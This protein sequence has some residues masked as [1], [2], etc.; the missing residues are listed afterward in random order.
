MLFTS[1]SFILFIILLFLLY[2]II[3]KKLQWKLL[4][5]A[6]YLFYAFAGPKYLIYI[7][8]TTVSTYIA[9]HKLGKLHKEQDAYLKEHK[10]ELDREGKKAYKAVM[11]SKQWKWLLGTLLLNFGILFVI[12]YLNFTIININWALGIFG[13]QGGLSFVT[14][15]LP[16]GISFYTFQ[17]MG[18]IIDVYRGKFPPENNLGKLALFVSFFPQLI[19]GPISRYDDLAKT[20]YKE[21]PLEFKN[22]SFGIQRI[23]WGFFKKLVIADRM[24]I[25]VKTLMGDTS[26]YHGAFVVV[27]M[28]FYTFQLY[29]D[30]T[31]GIDITIGIAEV[32][33]ISVKENFMRPYFSKNIAEFW[34]RWHITLGTWFTDYLFYPI[35]AWQPM[36][37]FS[38]FAR[39]RFGDKIGKK[40]PV[41][42]ASFAVW[43]TT[44]VWHGSSWNFIVW[45]LVNYAVLMGSEE[46]KPFYRWFHERFKVEGK[47]YFRLFQIVRTTLLMSAIRLFDVYRDVPATFRM[48]GS[49]FTTFNWGELFTGKLLT[50]GLTPG[51]YVVLIA[52]FILMLSVSLLQRRG[53]V[54]ESLA[55]KPVLVRNA[56]VYMLFVA[57]IIFGAYGVGYDSSQFIYNQ[58]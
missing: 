27:L 57:I 31:G 56:L 7:I 21:H 20:L 48:F 50:L 10:K 25:A 46:L 16:L 36:L 6:S 54:R 39:K 33:G 14:L 45:G 47:F 41:Y 58:F 11:K 42:A 2:Y 52:G 26:S 24:L 8:I 40:L 51:D 44:G 19:Q 53:S 30:F 28:L 17:T 35:S 12:K 1:Y 29:A 22:I 43:F 38:K 4:L 5:V 13:R 49:I 18:Y 15:A 9:A 23:L 55:A 32:L 37:K 3:P 34:K